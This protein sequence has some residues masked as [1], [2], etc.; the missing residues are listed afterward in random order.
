MEKRKK[1]FERVRANLT[2][3]LIVSQILGVLG[4]IML[5]STIDLGA[6]G[7]LI[8]YAIGVVFSLGGTVGFS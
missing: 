4:A 1:V 2:I 6:S 3:F 7:Y 8:G 5:G